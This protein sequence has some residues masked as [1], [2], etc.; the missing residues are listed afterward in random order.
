MPTNVRNSNEKINLDQLLIPHLA[1]NTHSSIHTGGEAALAAYPSDFNELRALLAYAAEQGLKVT[2]LGGSS[3]TLISDDGIEGLT[4]LT[5]HLARRHVQGELFCARSGCVLDKIIDQA[6]EDGL[7]GLELLGGI[8]GTVGGA[9]YGNSGANGLQIADL[10][11]Y[12]DYMTL[13]GKMHRLQ[14]HQDEFSYRHSPFTGRKDIIIYEAGFRLQPTTQTSDVRK[15][16]D[17]AKQERRNSGQYDN[18]SLGSIFKNP[19]DAS[20]GSL[21]EACN[22]KGYSIGGAQISHRHANVIINTHGKA[23]SNDVRCLIEY[24]KNQV[25]RTHHIELVEEINYAGRW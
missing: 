3:N 10:L 8:P 5:N 23:T 16:K 9:I 15:R 19:G 25:Y 13:D 14:I 7:S 20:A 18:P 21:I 6:I 1:L 12:V 24:V 11:Y 17:M 2:V 4:I 22:L